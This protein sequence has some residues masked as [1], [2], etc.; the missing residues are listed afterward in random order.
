MEIIYVHCETKWDMSDPD[1]YEHYWTSGWNESWKKK[2][3]GL[4]EIWIHDLCDTGIALYQLS[5]KPTGSSH[6]NGSK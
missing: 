1:S 3:A 6:N 4:Y 2:N 5:N